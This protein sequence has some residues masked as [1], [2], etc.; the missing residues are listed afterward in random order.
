MSC[1][2]KIWIY[3]SIGFSKCLVFFDRYEEL[4]KWTKF[5][6][7]HFKAQSFLVMILDGGS[8]L[9]DQLLEV[10]LGAIRRNV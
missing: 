9:L 7:K 8:L 2:H 5:L 6:L 1:L 3:N 4:L 10:F